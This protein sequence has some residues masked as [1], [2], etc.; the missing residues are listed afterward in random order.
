MI[1]NY[2]VLKI[3]ILCMVSFT[4]CTDNLAP[5]E[6]EE[7]MEDNSMPDPL[8][9]NGGCAGSKTPIYQEK[10]G[11]LLIE[12]ESTFY[13][14]TFWRIETD[15]AGYDGK[16]YLV[17]KGAD[18]FNNPGKGPLEF[19]IRVESTGTY[20]FVWRSYIT[21][22]HDNT[23]FNDSWL[24]IADA[25]HF[26]GR[27]GDGHIV[28]PRGS[29]QE[30]ISESEGQGGTQPV[31]SSSEGWFKIYMNTADEWKWRSTT[32]DHDPHN[33]F[34][35]FSEPGDYTVEISGR[36]KGH[37]IDKFVLFNENHSIESASKEEALSEVVCE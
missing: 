30:P 21:E 26:Y 29:K 36:S 24:R 17:W 31:G 37:G 34:V 27:K 8:E 1:L 28:Y 9:I 6:M 13:K 3:L 18:S 4:S 19:K 35:V 32:S 12:M 16:G 33:I 25:K 22:G 20:Q 2:P 11:L 5:E 10:D 15:L 14:P 7:M 23:E